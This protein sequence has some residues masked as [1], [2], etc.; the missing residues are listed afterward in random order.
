[1]LIEAMISMKYFEKAEK[2]LDTAKFEGS[3]RYL[4]EIF[5]GDLALAKGNE[6]AA[7]DIWE[8][9]PDNDWYGQYEAG[10]RFN[11]LNDYEKAVECFNNAYKAQTAPHKID[12]IYSLAF[13]YKK[14]GRFNDAKKEWE[15]IVETLLSEYAKPEEDNDI[16]WAR[17][18]IKQLDALLKQV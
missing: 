18:E 17:R 9:V 11:R 1:M 13:L 15:L 2:L 10:E 16:Q 12:M 7:K 8:S 14:L 3:N 5:L 6:Q 4:K